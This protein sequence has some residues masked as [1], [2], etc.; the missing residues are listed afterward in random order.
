MEEGSG[1]SAVASSLWIYGKYSSLCIRL[2]TLM[3]PGKPGSGKTILSGSIIERLKAK[4]PDAIICYYHFNSLES[5]FNSSCDAFRAI[6]AQIVQQ[7][8][9]NQRLK[10]LFAF[11]MFFNS[12]GQTT[13]S[14]SE[15]DELFNISVSLLFDQKLYLVL[16]GV[17]ECFDLASG[18]VPTLTKVCEHS[19]ISLILLSRETVTSTVRRIPNLQ[20]VGISLNNQPDIQLFLSEELKALVSSR[21]LPENFR[22]KDSAAKLVR[23]ADGMFL[24]AALMMSYVRLPGLLQPD[25]VRALSD[26]ALPE[27]LEVMYE[28]IIRYISNQASVSVTLACFVLRWLVFTKTDLYLRQLVDAIVSDKGRGLTRDGLD[29]DQSLKE[30]FEVILNVCG[31]FVE[32]LP[33][34]PQDSLGTY[35]VRLVHA[36]VREYLLA[37]LPY[38]FLQKPKLQDLAILSSKTQGNLA[39]AS[40]C[41][42]YLVYSIPAQPISTKPDLDAREMFRTTFPFGEYAIAYWADHL[43]ALSASSEVRNPKNKRLTED[44]KKLLSRLNSFLSQPK[45]ITAWI[46]ACYIFRLSLSFRTL[47]AWAENTSRGSWSERLTDIKG[48]VTTAKDLSIYLEDLDSSWGPQL[49]KDPSCVWVEVGAFSPSPFIAKAPGIDVSRLVSEAPKRSLTHSEPI[50]KISQLLVG[51]SLDMVLSVYPSK[52]VS[53]YFVLRRFLTVIG[54]FLHAIDVQVNTMSSYKTK[55]IPWIGLHASSYLKSAHL[56]SSP[57]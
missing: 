19:P 55:N 11:A 37:G 6:L 45:A 24:W 53:H 9:D 5:S 48:I 27:G 15:I 8:S 10:D 32:Y 28:R 43:L 12:D 52:Y 21:H 39:L 18:L 38:G 46:E 14:S 29:L 51:G 57:F 36:S 49:C 13:A 40:F 1:C 33:L 2:S 54:P 22:V 41:L 4:H 42:E 20:T 47:R 35:H 34:Q 26:L 7:S 56:S 44:L 23:R 50:T 25:R 30:L 31:G 3:R 17:D 16:D